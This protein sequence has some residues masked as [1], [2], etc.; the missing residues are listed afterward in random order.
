MK[1]AL[2]AV[3]LLSALS[4]SQ[5]K[6]MDRRYVP[7][8]ITGVQ[9][10]RIDLVI[11]EW[12]A[13][14]YHR[15]SGT[16]T[17]VPWQVDEVD[18]DKKY[19]KEKDGL[20]DANDEILCMP[21]DLGDQ[22]QAAEWLEDFQARKEQRIEL[23][24]TEP[25]DGQKKGWLYLYR[26]VST[27]QAPPSYHQRYSS[28]PAGTAA[29]TARTR[30]YTIGH[31]RDG[32]IDFVSLSISPNTDLVDRLKLRFSGDTPFGGMGKY[33]C[34]EDTLNNGS[35]SYHFGL[36]RAFHDQ[37]TLFS[38]PK[39]WS[40]PV[41]ADYQLEYYPYSYRIGV[42]GIRVDPLLLAVAGLK[43]IRQSLDLS[44]NAAGGSFYSVSN[45]GGV[46]IDGK[47]DNIS[48]TLSTTDKAQWLLASGSWG[49]IMMILELPQIKN[50]VT[51]IYYRDN[52]QGGT[53]DGSLDTGDQSSYCDM[54][55]WSY[56][57]ASALVTDRLNIDFNC[58][59]ID[60]PN[61]NALFGAQL[62]Q[63][64]QTEPTLTYAEQSYVQTGVLE[65]NEQPLDYQLQPG[66]PNPFNA[67]STLWQ[68]SL[69]NAQAAADVEAVV[70]NLLGQKIAQLPAQGR[71]QGVTWRWDGRDA[72][73]RRVGAGLYL[74]QIRAQERVW[75]QRVLV[76]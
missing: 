22:A 40:K 12:S 20:L 50:S 59:F 68:T 9:I 4:H 67:R 31:N 23:T 32:W 28:A 75:T 6:T 25:N 15:T 51:K 47:T 7:I 69:L 35:S 37:R 26:N 30:A 3:L 39:L 52:Q 70:Y 2:L 14:R 45:P 43:S 38:I 48:T 66:Y 18:N 8:S 19:N 42:A 36:I 46:S 56:T 11:K 10:P 24:F 57:L 34:S 44:P 65:H 71:A 5:V 13:Y 54:G 62:F 60:E 55:L 72:V 53:A 74:V 27:D 41:N 58:Y 21:E 64:N 73:G 63:W 17:L 61:Q 1:K 29:D 33:T 49:T 16:W 76:D